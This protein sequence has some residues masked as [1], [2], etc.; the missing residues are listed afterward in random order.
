LVEQGIAL[1]AI[2]K[3]QRYVVRGCRN[4]AEFPAAHM[5]KGADGS[6]SIFDQPAHGIGRFMKVAAL[7][8]L[9]FSPA[10]C[11]EH[12]DSIKKHVPHGKGG[13]PSDFPVGKIVTEHFADPAFGISNPPAHQVESN[14]G[15]ACADRKGNA[16]GQNVYKD[17]EAPKCGIFNKVF[18]S[19]FH[20]PKNIGEGL[21]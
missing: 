4:P 1:F 9:F 3:E 11:P 7:C 18:R 13:N 15:K 17:L 16:I 2:N 6:A 8:K 21:N 12:I 10:V 19:V 5:R 14:P 20:V